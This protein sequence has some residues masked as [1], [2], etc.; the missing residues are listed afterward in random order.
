MHMHVHCIH[1]QQGMKLHHTPPRAMYDVVPVQS[2][3]A[4]GDII[5]KS[6]PE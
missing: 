1:T 3:V 4:S 2:Q 6:T 5:H